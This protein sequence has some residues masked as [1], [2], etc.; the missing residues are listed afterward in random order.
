VPHNSKATYGGMAHSV[1]ELMAVLMNL[2]PSGVVANPVPVQERLR[3]WLC[4]NSPF[5]H[6]SYADERLE[7]AR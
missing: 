1:V 6:H 3:G 2:A 7:D 5:G 4:G